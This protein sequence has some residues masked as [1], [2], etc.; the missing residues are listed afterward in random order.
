VADW[1]TTDEVIRKVAHML[2]QAAEDIAARHLVTCADANERAHAE[3]RAVLASMRYAA[4]DVEL[5]SL[6]RIYARDQ[7]AY[8][9][10]KTIRAMFATTDSQDLEDTQPLKRLEAKNF[11]LVLDDGTVASPV[12][13]GTGAAVLTG[14]LAVRADHDAARRE[15]ACGGRNFWDRVRRADL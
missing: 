6:R 5:W 7:A 11:Q 2:G 14:T 8:Y 10:A 4:A 12:T 1:V 15:A 13:S 3:F 9:A